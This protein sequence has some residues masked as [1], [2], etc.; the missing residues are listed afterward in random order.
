MGLYL[1]EETIIPERGYPKP[2]PKPKDDLY[3]FFDS[4]GVEGT[5]ESK[6]RPDPDWEEPEP[7]K[8][9][10]YSLSKATDIK[11]SPRP[12]PRPGP[13]RYFLNEKDYQ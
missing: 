4:E 2:R 8:T 13:K 9:S 5:L 3:G 1:Q 12:A 6:I 7:K 10:I 11:P